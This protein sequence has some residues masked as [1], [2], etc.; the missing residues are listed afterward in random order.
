MKKRVKKKHEHR[1]WLRNAKE[2]RAA[3][4]EFLDSFTHKLTSEEIAE[5]IAQGKED[6]KKEPTIND[7]TTP[8]EPVKPIKPIKVEVVTLEEQ[9]RV[10]ANKLTCD[11]CKWK[12]ENECPWDL[13]YDKPGVDYADDCMDFK[14]KKE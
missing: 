9:K 10:N 8:L 4:Q 7:Y 13:M 5:C 6:A 11:D 3:W 1:Y 14:S 2:R 12:V